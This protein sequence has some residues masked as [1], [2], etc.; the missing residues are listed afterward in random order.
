MK[1]SLNYQVPCSENLFV[2]RERLIKKFEENLSQAQM[3]S[4]FIKGRPGIGK[5]SL[6]EKMVSIARSKGFLILKKQVPLQESE[7]F[8]D[9][10]LPEIKEIFKPPKPKKPG[11]KKAG[12]TTIK[13]SYELVNEE[14]YI[15]DFLKT[16]C[17]NKILFFGKELTKKAKKG[18]VIFVD[19]VERFI[20]LANEK[21]FD[22]FNEIVKKFEEIDEKK[23]LEPT[24]IIFVLFGEERYAPKIEY[25]LNNFEII[26]V[27]KMPY[28]DSIELLMKRE[29]NTGISI[30]EEIRNKLIEN[31]QGIPQL[32][33]Y[34]TSKLIEESD[35]QEINKSHWEEFESI[36]KDGFNNELKDI[37]ENERK[38]LQAFAMEP[39]NFADVDMLMRATSVERENILNILNS[40]AQS[41]H[42]S[43][44]GESYFISMTSFWEFLRDS[45]GDI[46]I[47]ATCRAM[48][49]IAENDAING[50]IINENLFNELEMLRK[51]SIS[52]GLVSPIELIAR[53]YERIANL[54]MNFNYSS[55]AYK[56]FILGSESYLKVNEIEKSAIILEEA[57]YLYKDKGM[58][59]YS[60]DIL[61]K[62]IEKYELLEDN[63]KIRELKIEVAENSLNKATISIGEGAFPL[64]RANFSRAQKFYG[65]IGED[66]K[67]LEILNKAASLFFDKGEHY[68]AWQYFSRI[69][70]FYLEKNDKINAKDTFE[71]ASDKFS[72]S[73]L[74]K[75]TEKLNDE[76]AKIVGIG[77]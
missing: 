23:K 29:S 39:A 27:P 53:G 19:N 33:L 28:K 60:R 40:L 35:A 70:N 54:S 47:A 58:G 7:A 14:K 17:N 69:I 77:E 65:E 24:P 75:Y 31:S 59:D 66:I 21:A 64:A 72:S 63:E 55:E 3:K 43:C 76:F 9:E 50:R 11:K 73:K 41:G 46:A 49:K 68:Y 1:E 20:F 67:A 36:I 10:L 13:K 4:I 2:G 32:L 42:V 38:I 62:A 8:F 15:L 56:F 25:S 30:E 57:G 44:E 34:N 71:I 37:T 26:G 5:S 48:I 61:L 12:K 51:D 6:L 52:A 74:A 16:F 18:I 22:L 45:L